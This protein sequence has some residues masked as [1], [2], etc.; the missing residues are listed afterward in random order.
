VPDSQPWQSKLRQSRVL[1]VEAI[2]ASSKSRIAGRG[3][4][5]FV[6]VP[7]CWSIQSKLPHN[8]LLMGGA[9]NASSRRFI[10]S[11]ANGSADPVAGGRSQISK[12]RRRVD[13]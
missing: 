3:N 13:P 9:V 8:L 5:S 2:K 7:D 11:P 10:D 1:L 6:K 12:R 4:Q